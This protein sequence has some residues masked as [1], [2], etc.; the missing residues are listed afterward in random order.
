MSQ[1][2]STLMIRNLSDVFGEGD[3]QRLRAAIDEI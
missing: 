2:I 1:S 3:P